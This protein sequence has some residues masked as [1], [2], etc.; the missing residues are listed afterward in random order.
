MY[1][2]YRRLIHGKKTKTI[3]PAIIHKSGP[4]DVCIVWCWSNAAEREGERKNCTNG[5]KGTHSHVW[6]SSPDL[7]GHRREDN[8][9]TYNSKFLDLSVCQSKRTLGP[10]S[11]QELCK[12]LGMQSFQ[13][14]FVEKNQTKWPLFFPLD[15]LL[16]N[17]LWCE[18][19]RGRG[20]K[21]RKQV[22]CCVCAKRRLIAA[23]AARSSGCFWSHRRI[24]A[25]HLLC[26]RRTDVDRLLRL[27][28]ILHCV[29][30][31]QLATNKHAG[32]GHDLHLSVG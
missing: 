9:I 28:Y 6:G 31:L 32:Y 23:K 29:N 3:P 10:L 4:L 14:V 17:A 18:S 27:H 15:V 22:V 26:I 12:R 2:N 30:K 16:Q 24:Y 13:Q 11:L 21:S 1:L 7:H 25:A 8:S 19:F 5:V 20:E